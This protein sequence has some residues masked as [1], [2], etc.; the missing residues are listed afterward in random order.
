MEFQYTILVLLVASNLRVWL[1]HVAVMAEQAPQDTSDVAAQTAG[2]R[3]GPK[4]PGLPVR[5]SKGEKDM[6]D[7]KMVYGHDENLAQYAPCLLYT[8]PSPRDLSTSRM[9]SSA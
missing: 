1:D 4:L 6:K 8:S 2:E 3:D 9:P 7:P 5:T